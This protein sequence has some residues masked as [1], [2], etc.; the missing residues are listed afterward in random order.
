GT[1]L[2]F[3]AIIGFEVGFLFMA[4]YVSFVLGLI[5]LVFWFMVFALS[6]KKIMKKRKKLHAQET[7]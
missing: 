1:F 2:T 5:T 3:I 6:F 4:N 7:A